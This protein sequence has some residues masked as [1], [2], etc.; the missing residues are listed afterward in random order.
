MRFHIHMTNTLRV[1]KSVGFSR[2]ILVY[3]LVWVVAFVMRAIYLG[4]V[5]HEPAFAL[6]VGDAVTY[7]GWAVR[8]ANGDWLGEGVFYQAPLYPYFLGVLYAV[9]GRDLLVVRLVQIAL[10]SGSCVLLARAAR[11]FFSQTTIGL[12]A[13][14]LLAVYPTAIFFDCSIQKSVLDLF[15]VCALLAVLGKL[16][17]SSQN[18]WK[19]VTGV[20]LGLLALTRE[21]ALLFLPIVLTWLFIAWRREL[22]RTRLRWAGLVL[23]GLAAILLPVG[24]RNLLVGGEFHLTTAQFGPNFYIGNGRTAT[25]FYESLKEGRGLALFERDDATTLAEQATG[26]KLTPSEVSHYWAVKAFNDIRADVY[27]WLRLV[28]KKWLLVW[29]ISEVADSDDQYTYGDWSP[30]LQLLN[31]ILHFGILCPLA[32]LGICLTWNRRKHVWLLY[33]MILGYAAS[34]ALFYVFSRYR[35]PLVPMLI[36]FAVAGLTSLRDAIRESRW[37]ALW[38]GAA[39]AVVA[40]AVCNHAMVPEAYIRAGTHSNFG[41]AFSM[42]GKIQDAIG[43]Y[44]QALR[45]K[46]DDPNIPFNL[47]TALLDAGRFE[48]AIEY[49]EQAL[50][51]NPNDARAHYSLGVAWVKLGQLS[52]AIG[53]F[54]QALRIEPDFAEAHVILGSVLL[55]Q[56]KVPEAIAHWEQALQIKPTFAE[57][58]YNLANALLRGGRF[59]EAIKNYEQVLRIKPDYAEAHCNLGIALERVGRV[60]AAIEH[61]EQAVLLRPDLAEVQKRLALVH[62]GQQRPK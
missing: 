54:E 32:V 19:L 43:Q 40:A 37:R 55:D 57:A 7:D 46:P 60:Q 39:I 6:L 45:L 58:R 17:E 11:S 20:I 18:R 33:A 9:F 62:A 50:R 15:F 28:F 16:S 10:G 41:N 1:G 24:C 49:Y 56:D 2:E 51:I 3:L 29:N 53:H 30:L 48:E 44:E 23:L 38:T 14:V 8:I 26:Q 31:R 47:A 35:F 42:E 13:G 4:Q 52:E 61:Y 12:W 27:R 22:W 59:E 25:G 34:V 36:L 5:R 21:N